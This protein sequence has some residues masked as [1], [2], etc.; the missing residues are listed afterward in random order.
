MFGTPLGFLAAHFRGLV[1]E[2]V[3]MLV[4]FQAAMPFMILAL[5]VLAFFGNAC[6]CSSR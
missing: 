4:D 3:M 2:L 6:R 1:D 5:S